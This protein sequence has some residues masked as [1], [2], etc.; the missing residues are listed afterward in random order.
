MPPLALSKRNHLTNQEAKEAL[1]LYRPGIS[2]ARDA[3]FVEAL[4]CARK[5]PELERWFQEHCAVQGVLRDKFRQIAVPE[6][7]KEQILSERQVQEI[8]PGK[9][10]ALA[11]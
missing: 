2:D 11:I 4:A 5:D 10:T 8:A 1:L 3:E 6:G 9:R 7:L